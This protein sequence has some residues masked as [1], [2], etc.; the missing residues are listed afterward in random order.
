MQRQTD[1]TLIMPVLS[2]RLQM[3]GAGKPNSQSAAVSSANG[4]R[5]T[6][7]GGRACGC[8]RGVVRELATLHGRL[9]VANQHVRQ[10]P[11]WR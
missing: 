3:L 1:R 11:R 8:G 2:R 7:R 5:H 9:T 10:C 6:L 4:A